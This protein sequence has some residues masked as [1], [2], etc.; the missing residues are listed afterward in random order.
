[1]SWKP[2]LW[3]LAAVLLAGAFIVVF[4]RGTQ[5]AGLSTP[6]EAPLLGFEPGNVTSLAINTSNCNAV[7]MLRNQTWFLT[8]P[9]ETRAD[10]TCIRQLLEALQRTRRRDTISGAL[11][12]QRGL[13]L[14]SFG[15][16]KPRVRCVVGYDRRQ[17][18]IVFGMD[19]PLGDLIYAQL[20]GG[21]DVVAVTREFEK[22]LPGSLDELRDHAVFPA[23]LRQL[24]RI[25]IKH[26][27]GF[28]QLASVGGNW[29]I[30]Q[31]KD[32][33]ADPARVEWL[34]GR[35]RELKVEAF[36]GDTPGADPVAYGMGPDE[37]AIEVTVWPEGSSDSGVTLTVGKLSQDNPSLFYA[38]I[39]DMGAI[40]MVAK[41]ALQPLLELR[42][43][44]LRDRRLCDANPAQ[45]ATLTIL[46]A[47][48]KLVAERLAAGGWAITEPIRGTA[49]AKVVGSLLKELCALRGDELPGAE[50]TNA[51][52]RVTQEAMVRVTIAE[53]QAPRPDSLTNA[54]PS[55]D[56]T[57]KRKWTYWIGTNTTRGARLILRQEDQMV[58]KVQTA[59][60]TRLF[61]WEATPETGSTADPLRY[62]DRR[63]FDLEADNVRRL[64]LTKAGRE[65]TVVKNAGG[66][67]SVDSPPGTHVA[68]GAVAALLGLAGDLK[69]VRI[70]SVASTNLTSY[71]FDEASPRL[72]FG[73]TGTGGIQKTILLGGTD[74]RQ[75]VYAMVQGRD[76]VFVLPRNVAEAL[77]HSLVTSP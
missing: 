46:D 18:E 62:M 66:N 30:Q 59:D 47:E 7:C 27:G 19:V 33:P 38:R 58:F 72:T 13:T 24:A 50:I 51:A 41:S 57:V 48:K 1:M 37:A 70:E 10:G 61:Q 15:L 67:W 76:V 5:P 44:T 20:N 28:I 22:A 64:T 71:G 39:S 8:R 56:T 36:G 3:L 45:V 75:G 73:L 40:G 60:L 49:D 32:A 2:T 74:Q 34:L 9:V 21:E 43:E 6:L 69:A 16:D 11:Q 52:M 55:V 4:E 17:D 65:E 31:P 26:A 29:R 35:L 12:Q 68:D 53:A 54:L 25:E 77:T 42:A 14:E 63:V 23:T